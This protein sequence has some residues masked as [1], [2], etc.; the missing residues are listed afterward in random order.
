MRDFQKAI[1]LLQDH[2][3]SLDEGGLVQLALALD[4]VGRQKE[5]IDMLQKRH[6]RTDYTD[7]MGTLAGRLKRRWLVNRVGDDAEKAS[8]LY[9]QGFDLSE[10]NQRHDQAFYH[11]INVAFMQLAYGNQKSAAQE[12]AKI[13]LGHC[14]KAEPD[15]WQSATEGDAHLLLGETDQAIQAYQG[16]INR[17]PSPRELDSM[18]QQAMRM[19]SLLGDQAAGERLQKVFRGQS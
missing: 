19:A 5:A 12:T 7:A 15:K 3:E 2:P 6:A 17:N 18:L 8:A 13:V 9:Q 4:S 11:G 1:Q 14:A 16:A 10:K